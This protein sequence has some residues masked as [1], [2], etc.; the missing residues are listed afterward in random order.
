MHIKRAREKEGVFGFCG[1]ASARPSAAAA[2]GGGRQQTQRG[3]GKKR[4]GSAAFVRRGVER[5]RE[6]EKLPIRGGAGQLGSGRARREE[7]RGAGRP[8]RPPPGAC[9]APAAIRR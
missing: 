5:E 3:K 7:E 9:G 8:F 4:R 1:A 6:T 2:A